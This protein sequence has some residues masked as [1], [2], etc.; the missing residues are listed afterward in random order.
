MSKRFMSLDDFMSQLTCGA[1]DRTWITEG[2]EVDDTYAVLQGCNYP[3]IFTTEDGEKFEVEHIE[4]EG[5]GEGGSEYCYAVI[6]VGEKFYKIEYS[7]YSHDGYD[8]RDAELL[9]VFPKQQTITVYE[10]A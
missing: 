6:K 5:G 3:I 7:Y 1:S 10:Y 9:E 4:Q 8:T 2:D